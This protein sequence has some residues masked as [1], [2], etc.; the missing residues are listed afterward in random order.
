MAT[1]DRDLGEAR[2][3][4]DRGDARA[5][6]KSLD[7][8][9]KGYARALDSEGLE[10]VL[11]MAALVD[12]SDDRIRIGRENLA[13]AAKQ[14]L[15]Q[16][17]RRR[18]RQLGRDW[19]DPFPDLQAPTEHTGLV[20]TR[21][22]KLWIGVGVARRDR[23]DR[24]HR[25]RERPGRHRPEDDRHAAATTTTPD[26][27]SPFGRAPTGSARAERSGRARRRRRRSMRT[28]SSRSSGST[29]PARTSACRCASTTA[30][31]RSAGPTPSRRRSRR[32]RRAPGRPCSRGPAAPTVRRPSRTRAQR[33]SRPDAAGRRR[34]ASSSVATRPARSPWASVS[35]TA[36]RTASAAPAPAV[37]PRASPRSRSSW[38]ARSRP[39]S[40]SSTAA[41]TDAAQSPSGPPSSAASASRSCSERNGSSAKSDSSQRSSA[42]ASSGSSSARPRR[43]SKSDASRARKESS[44]VGSPERL[45][46]RDRQHR[47]DRQRPPVE[48]LE[49]HRPHRDGRCSRKAQCADRV[50]QLARRVGCAR[51]VGQ[52]GA[53]ELEHAEPVRL[54]AEPG[55][56]QSVRLRPVRGQLARGR[57]PNPQP[58]G[59]LHLRSNREPE[60][61]RDGGVGAA[62][63]E[64]RA[65][66]LDVGPVEGLVA[67]VE[68][69][70]GL[71]DVGEQ[72][73]HDR[74]Q[75][76]LVAGLAGMGGGVDG[77]GGLAAKI[78]D[79]EP[80][81]GERAQPLGPRLDVAAGERPV[82]VE[83]ARPARGVLLERERELVTACDVVRE[84]REARQTEQAQ[85]AVEVRG[86]HGH[87]WPLRARS[88]LSSL[89]AGA[90][91]GGAVVV[92]LAARADRCAAARARP[93]G[94]P[95]DDA[96]AA[97]AVECGSHQ[98]RG[99]AEHAQRA[100]RLTPGRAAARARAARATATRPSRRSR[101]RRRGAGRARRRRARGLDARLAAWRPCR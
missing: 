40:P 89:A 36:L 11:D 90:P 91:V 78:L 27:R 43:A 67:P 65:L 50:G 15:R 87:G 77:S 38:S 66:E 51:L 101:S 86:A 52:Q 20:L 45:G 62:L 64:E 96:L 35:T 41:R 49:Q 56:Q 92:A 7:R 25:P 59:E 60:Q 33:S 73:Q 70:A 53:L 3:A 57:D 26:G 44:L 10:H 42:S 61:R 39:V 85:G 79:R 37:S 5:A 28:S 58:V 6:L 48:P 80:R 99:F 47:T 46:R 22:V 23:R 17:S 2:A 100:P 21:G 68:A 83:R 24:R 63:A 76:R 71:G 54:G 13:Y 81:V 4:I 93:P 29:S 75:E 55:R 84:Q 94:A 82:L 69:A 34:S 98:S 95:V 32:R 14:N 8:A 31:R 72:R 88:L 18:A 12:A 16:E 19:T 74:P 1:P 97:L 30:T 9:R